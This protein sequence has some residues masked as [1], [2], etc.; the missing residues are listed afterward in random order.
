MENEFNVDSKATIWVEFATRMVRI[1]DKKLVKAQIWDTAGQEHYHSLASSYC[2][3]AVGVPLT[4]NITD[5]STF[6]N[7]PVWLKEVE[8]NSEKD[9][10]IMLVGNKRSTNSK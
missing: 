9:C 4:N 6:N 7:I 1:K 5:K 3:G 2:R 10:L 8:D